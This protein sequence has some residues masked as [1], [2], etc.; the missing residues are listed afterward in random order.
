[1]HSKRD[2]L[3]I[4]QETKK[5]WKWILILVPILLLVAIG[6]P[7]FT[8]NEIM[9]NKGLIESGSPLYILWV[10]TTTFIAGGLFLTVVLLTIGIAA[11]IKDWRR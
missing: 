4:S 6:T 7:N 3:K 9:K 11:L 1:M 8:Y 2:L 10:Y 5:I